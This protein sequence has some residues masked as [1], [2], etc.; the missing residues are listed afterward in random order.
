MMIFFNMKKYTSSDLRDKMWFLALITCPMIL[1]VLP[2]GSFD[3][4]SVVLCPSRLFFDIECW[5]CGMTRAIMHM[6]HLD[7]E[8]AVY[9]NTGSLLVYPA[10]FL[11]WLSWTIKAAKRLEWLKKDFHIL[12]FFK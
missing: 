1:W 7:V 10:L 12:G 4:S 9:Y 3:N 11:V 5:G 2:S 8:S 6:H